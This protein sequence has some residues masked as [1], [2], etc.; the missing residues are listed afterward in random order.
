MA[1]SP[2]PDLFDVIVEPRY[3]TNFIPTAGTVGPLA[4]FTIPLGQGVSVWQ[5]AA[6]K[7]K[8]DTNMILASQLPSGYNF[9]LLGF[10]LMFSWNCTLADVQ[11]ALNGCFFTFTIGSKDYLTVPARTIP[12]GNGP[13]T[14]GAI[15]PAATSAAQANGWPSLANGYSI[16]RKPLELPQT[17]N[18]SAALAWTGAGQAV[19]TT[20]AGGTT[21]G[22][23][24]LPITCYLDG[25]L[26]RP[27]Q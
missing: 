11:L 14:G 21:A 27:T 12:G 15:T 1:L 16:A 3:D 18:F 10:R 7:S 22:A 19:T 8:A 5:T 6:V 23:A 4:F 13:W 2:V 9:V 25:F 24:G 26:K 20:M 17:V